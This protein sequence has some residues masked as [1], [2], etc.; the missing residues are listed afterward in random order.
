MADEASHNN[1]GD[2]AGVKGVDGDSPGAVGW[3]RVTL[4]KLATASLDEQKR[5]RRW[6]IFFR[7][8]F[9]LYLIWV[10]V[11][12]L[13]KFDSVGF[14]EDGKHVAVVE[15]RGIIRSGGEASAENI[16][17]TLRSA[18]KNENV[19]GVILRV[20]SPGGS[21][22][23]SSIMH[24]EI[25]RLRSK[26]PGKPLLA[27]IEDIGASGAY[28]V[29]SA[30]ERVYVNPSSIVGSIGVLINGFGFSEAL[31]K[32]GVERRLLTSGENKGF[33]DPFSPLNSEHEEYANSLLKALHQQFIAAVRKGR[34][35]RLQL[36]TPG[37]FSGLLWTG[38]ESI[39]IGLAD[40]EGSV[41]SVAREELETEQIR[42]YSPQ[43]NLLDRLEKRL[44]WGALANSLWRELYDQAAAPWL[45]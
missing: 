36:E 17:K 43:E 8:A 14:D 4:E 24:N 28:F 29:A 35:D 19:V 18:F 3:E 12:L 21:P 13:G 37:L 34:G 9:L 22:V 26:Y 38:A 27:V 45:R 10:T 33:L 30:A 41:S 2:S 39:G 5:R 23:Q 20:N 16:N 25:L 44:S 15:L 32:I 31:K 11:A 1:P 6:A 40:T 42:I 7:F